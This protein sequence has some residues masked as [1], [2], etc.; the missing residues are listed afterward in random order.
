MKVNWKYNWL[1]LCWKYKI[2]PFIPYLQ[3]RLLEEIWSRY[4]M[5]CIRKRNKKL[6]L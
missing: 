3:D 2:N 1:K 6:G 5:K 4:Y